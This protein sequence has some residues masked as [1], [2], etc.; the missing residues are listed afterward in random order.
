VSQQKPP[1]MPMPEP[2]SLDNCR[3]VH[4]WDEFDP[5]LAK[6]K[7]RKKQNKGRG[8]FFKKPREEK[9]ESE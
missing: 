3:A 9:P 1:P 2:S 8:G 7:H 6:P 4:Y 5:E